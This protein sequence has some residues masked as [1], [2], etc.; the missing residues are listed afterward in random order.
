MVPREIKTTFPCTVPDCPNTSTRRGYYCKQHEAQYAAPHATNNRRKVGATQ[1]RAV[2]HRGFSERL[3]ICLIEWMQGFLAGC[4]VPGLARVSSSWFQPLGRPAVCLYSVLYPRNCHFPVFVTSIHTQQ[5]SLCSPH[6]FQT[7][8]WLVV[9]LS[10]LSLV[11]CARVTS[12][13][14]VAALC[15]YLS[16]TIS[17]YV[18]SLSAMAS[19]RSAFSALLFVASPVSS[20]VLTAA[21]CHFAASCSSLRHSVSSHSW[22]AL[23]TP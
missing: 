9:R 20:A 12:H 8:R 2:S 10:S 13:S 17:L 7:E 22:H 3:P 23:R 4:I 6:V 16:L 19:P 18:T 21:L 1:C 5:L 15:S 11:F 14:D